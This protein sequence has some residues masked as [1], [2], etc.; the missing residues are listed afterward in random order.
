MQIILIENIP[1]LGN[2]GD[3]VKVKDGF[4][5]NF[6]I[7]QKKAKRVTQKN[8]AEFE[9]RRAELEK[10]Q[11][12]ILATAKAYLKKLNGALI[13]ISQKSGIE[14]KLFGSVT[15]QDI[16]KAITLYGVPVEK[17]AIKLSNGPFKML[18]EY[19]VKVILHHDVVAEI[20]I[21]IIAE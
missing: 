6:L 14:G 8:L 7:P 16:A 3:I 13:N 15:T 2:L 19:T 18:G 10:K 21:N 4:A 11:V 5:R 20:T 17:E 9:A 12:A 1:R